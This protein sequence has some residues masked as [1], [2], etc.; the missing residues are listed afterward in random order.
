MAPQTTTT[1]KAT[2]N[3]PADITDTSMEDTSNA[4][5]LWLKENIQQLINNQAVIKEQLNTTKY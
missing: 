1:A 2:S 5:I 3:R 4:D